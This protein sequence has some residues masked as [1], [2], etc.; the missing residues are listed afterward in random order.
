MIETKPS[1]SSPTPEI[2]PSKTIEPVKSEKKEEPK[3]QQTISK[4]PSVF[5]VKPSSK[6]VILSSV[7]EIRA[8]PAASSPAPVFSSIVEVRTGSAEPK[9]EI[10]SSKVEI[11]QAPSSI[12]EVRTGVN[13]KS[14]VAEN[15]KPASSIVNVH[16]GTPKPIVDV[17]VGIPKPVSIL[18]SKV[19]VIS[20]SDEP[21]ISGNNLEGPAEYD[22][23]SR[24]PSEVVDETYKVRT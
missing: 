2:A 23:L 14:N 15:P 5:E 13:V 18:S 6:T 24:Q 10:I 22:F 7:V 8:G 17:K 20:S 21:A 16:V 11:K 3:K 12:V 4:K 9:K 19:E 1:T